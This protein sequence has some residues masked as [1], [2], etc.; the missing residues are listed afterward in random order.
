M[1]RLTVLEVTLLLGLGVA[2]LLAAVSPAPSGP[3]AAPWS[4]ERDEAAR[5]GRPDDWTST[6]AADCASLAGMAPTAPITPAAL[7]RFTACIERR[8]ADTPGRRWH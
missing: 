1:T 4:Q 7:Q 8:L 5:R 2:V 3:P 6:L